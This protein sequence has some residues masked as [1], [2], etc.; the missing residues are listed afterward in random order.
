MEALKKFPLANSEIPS[1]WKLL[2]KIFT[3][4]KEGIEM[5][6]VINIS[7][8]NDQTTEYILKSLKEFG[9]TEEQIALI[10]SL[11]ESDTVK[12]SLDSQKDI[13][14][15]KIQT[16]KIPTII[17]NGVRHDRVVDVEGLK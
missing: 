9:Y 12:K 5:Q 2:D 4:K 14:E 13:V 16:I 3:D 17:F 8:T 7:Y 10:R 15:N 1:D 6:E 11:A